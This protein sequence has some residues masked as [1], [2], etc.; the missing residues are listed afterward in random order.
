MRVNRGFCYTP[1]HWH[2]ADIYFIYSLCGESLSAKQ[3][4]DCFLVPLQLGNQGFD[5]L[6]LL[7]RAEVLHELYTEGMLV[8]VALETELPSKPMMCTSMLRSVPLS[9]VGR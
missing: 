9:T 8:Q 2:F 3:M 4:D 6:E 5:A 1:L 7:L